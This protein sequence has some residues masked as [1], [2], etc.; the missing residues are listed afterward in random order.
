MGQENNIYNYKTL[1]KKNVEYL[2]KNSNNLKEDYNL[3]DD[4][5]LCVK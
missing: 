1:S 5:M 4:E 3:F 2:I